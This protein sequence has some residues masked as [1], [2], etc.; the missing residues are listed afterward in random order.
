M[1]FL[2]AVRYCRRS[3]LSL[4][5]Y[6]YRLCLQC[7]ALSGTEK[8][9]AATR[10]GSRDARDATTSLYVAMPL[11]RYCPRYW[12]TRSLGGVRY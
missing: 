3:C 10:R 6:W 12:P 4:Y 2:D 1:H 8:C 5:Q 11:L 9:C 7:D